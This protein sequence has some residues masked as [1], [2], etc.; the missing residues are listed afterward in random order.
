MGS[1]IASTINPR[2]RAESSDVTFPQ[3]GTFTASPQCYCFGENTIY[4][5]LA[6][7]LTAGS[8]A[9]QGVKEYLRCSR[10]ARCSTTTHS[11]GGGR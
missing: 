7:G 5:G 3:I 11:R 6:S 9:Q 1:I 10:S 2:G 4:K 8:K